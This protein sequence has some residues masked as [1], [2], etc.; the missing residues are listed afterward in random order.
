[1]FGFVKKVVKWPWKK[2]AATVVVIV[3]VVREFIAATRSPTK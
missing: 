2:I 3:Q 1:M